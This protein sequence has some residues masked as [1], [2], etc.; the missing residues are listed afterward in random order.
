MK[1]ICLMLCVLCGYALGAGELRSG[2]LLFVRA[3]QSS[4]D[5]AIVAATKSKQDTPNY[6]HVGI[7]EVD[8]GEVYVIEASP[9][10]G[11]VRVGLKQFEK[12]NPHYDVYRLK[13]K[14]DFAR[15]ITR[16]KGYLGQPYDFYYRVDNGKMYCTELVWES[17]LDERGA[18]IFEAKPMNFYD[19]KGRLPAYWQESFKK[20]GAQVPQGE[21]GT[22]P[23][24]MAQ[25]PALQK[26]R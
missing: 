7:V 14:Q 24:A 11:V 26:V 15:I 18:R 23:N 21:L 5:T 25:S 13:N 4:F 19:E 3:S 10:L 20:L 16:A 8:K 17:Y 9:E 2:D 1:R 6:T 22:N 12:A